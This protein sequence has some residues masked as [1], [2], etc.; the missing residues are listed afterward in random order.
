LVLGWSEK[1]G[2]LV[3]GAW[4]DLVAVRGDPLSDVTVLERP[5]FVMKDGT[6]Y[7][8][9]SAVDSAAMR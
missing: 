3:P 6:V 4:V 8:S 2:T 5:A 9:V 1:V 7:R